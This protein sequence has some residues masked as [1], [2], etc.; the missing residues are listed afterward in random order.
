MTSETKSGSALGDA[1]DEQDGDG[2]TGCLVRLVKNGGRL[3]CEPSA[4][5]ELPVPCRVSRAVRAVE[6]VLVAVWRA[7]GSSR[8]RY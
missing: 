8:R 3:A 7:P 2:T 4:R 1:V 5:Q 6:P